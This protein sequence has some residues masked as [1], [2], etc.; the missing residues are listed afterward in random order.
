MCS[1]LPACQLGT[2]VFMRPSA[3]SRGV[4]EGPPQAF[5]INRHCTATGCHGGS[6]A[7]SSVGRLCGVRAQ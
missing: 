3:A 6:T 7:L 4:P 2:L 5:G 1:R